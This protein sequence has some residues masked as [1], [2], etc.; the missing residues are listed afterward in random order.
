MKRFSHKNQ[1]PSRTP[2]IFV[3]NTFQKILGVLEGPRDLWK[4]CST[5]SVKPLEQPQ[6]CGKCFLQKLGDFVE[7]NLHKIE[8]VLE[9]SQNL[10]KVCSTNS[11]MF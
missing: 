9:V 8:G 10:W 4:V 11:M 1:G 5:N 6:F 2:W 7:N 3:Q